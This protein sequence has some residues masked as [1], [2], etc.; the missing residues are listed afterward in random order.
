MAKKASGSRAKGNI[1]KTV[2]L[3]QGEALLIWRRRKGW[4]Q[5]KAAKYYKLSLFNYKLAEYGLLR[6]FCFDEVLNNIG[7]LHSHEECLIYRK[8]S[9]KTQKQ[10]AHE[11]G[12]C[13][14]WLR[15]QEKGVQSCD[16]LLA[17]WERSG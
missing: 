9:K 14:Y 10:V 2:K 8:R 17:H 11:L 3:S 5:G 15:L 1:D 4:N 13:R 6:G 12:V 16:K 7:L